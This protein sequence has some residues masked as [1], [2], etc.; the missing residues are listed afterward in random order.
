[1]YGRL[2][3]N[4]IKR[5]LFNFRSFFALIA[6]LLIQWYPVYL[7]MS[8]SI[9]ENDHLY[10]LMVF[11]GMNYTLFYTVVAIPCAVA[12]PDDRNYGMTSYMVTR[13]SPK[14]YA[15]AK[16]MGAWLSY[17][18]FS[19]T[20]VLLFFASVILVT[21]VW[22][23]PVEIPHIESGLDFTRTYYA[24]ASKSCFLY[25]VARAMSISLIASMWSMISF[26]FSVY[27]AN[28]FLT[29]A[30][31]PIIFYFFMNLLK[32]LS[33]PF[34]LNP[35]VVSYNIFHLHSIAVTLLYTL[36]YSL[37][38]SGVLGWFS[39]RKMLKEVLHA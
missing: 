12:W 23:A 4:E 6:L 20:A 29:I 28:V 22:G 15:S 35:L 25:Y 11:T 13:S 30:V 18:L 37:V 14:R 17:F 8:C 9:L 38:I 16:T 19:V 36:M 32:E 2:I 3:G 34:Y 39:Y 10:Y 33:A 31:P 24:L 27:F 21:S 5:N 1:V 26:F 7:E